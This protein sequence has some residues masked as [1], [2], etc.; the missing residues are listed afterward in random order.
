MSIKPPGSPFVLGSKN[1]LLDKF[2]SKVTQQPFKRLEFAAERGKAVKNL[3]GTKAIF[4]A[5]AA[6][7]EF[8]VL[9]SCNT[10]N[11]VRPLGPDDSV[12]DDIYRRWDIETWELAG[13]PSEVTDL[14]ALETI[15]KL[16]SALLAQ[17]DAHI[18]LAA[19]AD[20]SFEMLEDMQLETFDYLE[21]TGVDMA[22]YALG[23]GTYIT[24]SDIII[25]NFAMEVEYEVPANAD[26]T[27]SEVLRSWSAVVEKRI[28]VPYRQATW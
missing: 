13:L 25:R 14:L 16:H 20:I 6:G 22:G 4:S 19:S 17:F 10:G 24:E 5:G 1:V 15:Y 28:N 23:D 8:Q 26:Y 18:E 21:T 11:N 7:Y 2:G 3:N 27:S 9:S 12:L